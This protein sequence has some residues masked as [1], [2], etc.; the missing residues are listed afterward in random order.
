M[1][2][3]APAAVLVFAA[4]ASAGCGDDERQDADAPT[5]TFG[6]DVTRAS[7]P[8]RQSVA[9]PAELRLDVRNTGSRA[10]PELA[11]TVET[12][13]RRGGAA[14]AAFGT[15]VVG[16]DL[17][18][19]VRPVW[20]LDQGPAGG[21]TAYANT[22]AL[23]PLARGATRRVRFAVT[24]ARAGRYRVRWRVAPALVGDARAAPGGRTSGAFRVTI[25]AAPVDSR[26]GPGGRVIRG[27]SG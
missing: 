12:A 18:D 24:A 26:V 10:I 20:V 11:V 17:G 2:R 27:P 3:R 13:G 14:P 9:E 1:R 5:G 8:A 19:R 4:L 7:F 22:W 25:S 6:L 21:D 23:G 15:A 16:E